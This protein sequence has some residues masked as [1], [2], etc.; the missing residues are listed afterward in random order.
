MGETAFSLLSS[1]GLA[2]M[3]VVVAPPE[4]FGRCLCS[5]S[6]F[7]SHTPHRETLQEW[8]LCFACLE[9]SEATA[10]FSLKLRRALAAREEAA[11]DAEG[12]M[13]CSE[14]FKSEPSGF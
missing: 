8:E 4:A 6:L 14:T 1:L 9:A 3:V 2:A 7:A 10:G 11:P 12:A 13:A 5:S